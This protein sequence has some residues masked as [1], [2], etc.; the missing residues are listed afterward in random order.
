M[1]LLAVTL[2]ENWVYPS[3]GEFT[4]ESTLV[5]AKVAEKSFGVPVSSASQKDTW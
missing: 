5:P 4:S 2:P 1:V 3:A